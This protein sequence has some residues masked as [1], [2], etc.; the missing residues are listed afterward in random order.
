MKIDTAKHK[1]VW[2][3]IW[4]NQARLAT[5]KYQNCTLQTAAMTAMQ[6]FRA[7]QMVNLGYCDH[8]L[9][10]SLHPLAK[11]IKRRIG[12]PM[13]PKDGEFEP[14]RIEHREPDSFFLSLP[15]E[16]MIKEGICKDQT[17]LADNPD[18][19]A[20]VRVSPKFRFAATRTALL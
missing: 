1:T 10:R 6:W 8:L 12:V 2:A 19:R 7:S 3:A 15:Y 18:I 16:S 9:R 11:E 4:V 14:F 5:W 17:I 13:L 20:V